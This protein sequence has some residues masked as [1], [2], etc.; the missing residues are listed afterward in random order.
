MRLRATLMLL[1]AAVSL[2]AYAPARDA[3]LAMAGQGAPISLRADQE[4]YRCN[5]LVVLQWTDTNSQTV[6]RTDVRRRSTGADTFWTV[7]GYT[8]GRPD[9]INATLRARG[10]FR[11]DAVSLGKTYRYQARDSIAG[12]ALTSWSDSVSITTTSHCRSS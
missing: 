7:R 1:A 4:T 10:K 11:D 3:V 2:A 5:A 9:S 12:A 8:T 6:V